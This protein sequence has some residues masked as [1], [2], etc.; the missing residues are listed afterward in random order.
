MVC[1][2]RTSVPDYHLEEGWRGTSDVIKILDDGQLLE[3]LDTEREHAGTWSCT[4]END[5]GVKE[6]EIQLDVWVPPVVRVSS[7]APIKSIGETVTLICEASG[8]PQ[9]S[10]GWTKGGQP[11]ISSAEGV[12]ISLKVKFC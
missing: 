2:E 11:I 5:A 1:C 6:M 7:E 4:A 3:I 12:R 9:P 8:N 10:L